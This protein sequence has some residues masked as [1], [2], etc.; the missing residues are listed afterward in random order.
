MNSGHLIIIEGPEN[1]GKT[2]LAQS[3]SAA[4]L[5][6]GILADY[7]SFPG[8]NTA[9]VGAVVY[10]LEHKPDR[11][12]LTALPPATR[13]VLHLAAHLDAIE[14]R[15]K[16][17]L[18]AG[19]WVVLDRYWW[20]MWAHGHAQGVS[21]SLLNQLVKIECDAWLP[22]KPAIIFC[23]LRPVPFDDPPTPQWENVRAAYGKL[24][25][26]QEAHAPIDQLAPDLSV[27]QRVASCL[28]RL[29]AVGVLPRL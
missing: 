25:E 26:A 28:A 27:E 16:P 29:T 23:T 5:Q 17:A 10:D 13:Q 8:R 9:S 12:G 1:T 15:I 2:T 6:R 22:T 3:L 19:R 14:S 18:A 11:F 20:S 4:L 21:S 7:M 24:V